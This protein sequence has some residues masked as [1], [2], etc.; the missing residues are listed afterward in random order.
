MLN[1][2]LATSRDNPDLP[3]DERILARALEERGARVRSLVWDDDA[4]GASAD[5]VVIRA[6]WDYHHDVSTFIRW[7]KS[8]TCVVNDASL[9]SWNAHK[10]YLNELAHAGIP[11]I[12]TVMLESIEA[13]AAWR[14]RSPWR[15]VVLKPAVSASGYMTE[16]FTL[17]DERADDHA[18]QIFRLGRE[19]LVQPFVESVMTDGE[20]SYVM[21]D[22]ELTHCVWRPPFGR[23]SVAAEAAARCI[24]PRADE[25]ELVHRT[26]RVLPRVPVYARVDIVRYNGAPVLSEAELI[27]PS[28][29]FALCPQAAAALADRIIAIAAK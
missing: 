5:L 28:L 19:T 22:S 7:V 20:R 10:R 29:Y 1:I 8:L 12:P 13:F 26:L 2:T 11:T 18:A 4:G 17:D 15:D 6:T 27:E 16:R 25:L 14:L 9:V 23:G 21:I 24:E 3:V